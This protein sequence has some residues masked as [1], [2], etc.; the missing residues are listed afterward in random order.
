MRYAR[1]RRDLPS[2]GRGG[3][4]C[5]ARERAARHWKFGTE[6]RHTKG[7]EWKRK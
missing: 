5:A 7:E 2:T 6:F 3:R 4:F 1:A